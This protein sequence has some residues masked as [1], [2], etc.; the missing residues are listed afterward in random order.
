MVDKRIRPITKEQ[1]DRLLHTLPVWVRERIN[2]AETKIE[3]MR[4]HIK[5][6]QILCKAQHQPM[7]MNEFVREVDAIDASINKG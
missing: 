1:Q 5:A 6:L 2:S 4:H 7:D 3:S